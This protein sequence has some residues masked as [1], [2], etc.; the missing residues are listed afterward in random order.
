M[1][2]TLIKWKDLRRG[3]DKIVLKNERGESVR[4]NIS[5]SK[6]RVEVLKK[7]V[8]EKLVV[9]YQRRPTIFLTTD[10]WVKDISFNNE[11][12]I[13][14]NYEQSKRLKDSAKTWLKYLAIILAFSAYRIWWVTRKS[15]NKSKP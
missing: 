11:F 4:L 15:T 12:I 2:A 5:L 6:Q 1:T 8:G 9:Y 14:Y 13:G 3:S 10:F 7:L